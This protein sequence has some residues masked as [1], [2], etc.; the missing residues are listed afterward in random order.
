MSFPA[1]LILFSFKCFEYEGDV[2]GLV[3][4]MFMASTCYA[5]PEIYSTKKKTNARLESIFTVHITESQ[6]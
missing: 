6:K 4:L 2:G 1:P 5:M 3:K